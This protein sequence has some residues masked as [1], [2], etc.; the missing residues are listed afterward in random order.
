MAN[1]ECAIRTNYFRVKDEG[2]FR[3]LID[4]VY[5]CDKRNFLWEKQEKTGSKLF[6][7][8]C[9]GGISGVRNAAEDEDDSTDE[10]AYDEFID[11]L[12]GCVAEDDAIIIFEIGNEK[13]RYLT[14][15]ALIVTSKEVRFIDLQQMAVREVKD[16]LSDPQ[17]YTSCEY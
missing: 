11:C 7:F 5:G 4:R 1:Y 16:M 9:Y 6:G 3:E 2:K 12:Q 14:G 15:T 10:S 17:W 8:G 13:L